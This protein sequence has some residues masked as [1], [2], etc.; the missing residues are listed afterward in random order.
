MNYVNLHCHTECSP[1]DGYSSINEYM[2]RVKDI[3]ATSLAITDHGTLHGH[4]EFQRAAKDSGIKP[5]LGLE[6]YFSPTDRF[7]RR[8]KKNR[9]E[10]DSIYHHLIL[11]PI[12][13]NGLN[14]LNSGNRIA[15]NEGFYL[16]PRWDM[17][18]LKEY[19]E[20]LIVLSGC[21]GGPIASAFNVGNDD[22]AYRWAKE[23]YDVFGDRFYI[24]L[25]KDNHI[26]NPDVNPKLFDLSDKLSIKPVIT[27]DCHAASPEDKI[28]QEIF[29]ILSSHPKLDRNADL[30]KAQ[31]M[32]LLE[33]FDYLYPDRKMTFKDFDLYLHGYEEK[34]NKMLDLGVDRTDIYENTVAIADRI[35]DYTYFSAQETLP[36]IV[37]NP[38]IT[39]R[40][41]T[42][43]GLI[44]K[45]LWD[46]P[47]YKERANYELE[48]IEGKGF[49][50]Y[51]LVM[52]DVVGWAHKQG[53]RSGAG[54]GSGAGSVVNYALC[55]TDVDPLV[56]NL[57]FE[58]FLDPERSDWPDVDWDIQDSR[59]D[60]VKQYLAEKYGHV[61]NITTVNTYKGKKALKDAARALGVKF[62]EVN[63]AMK[64][65]EGIDEITGHDVIAAFKK[66]NPDFNEK[67][68]DVVKI[69]EKL[70]GRITGYGLHA[71]GIIVA[72][73]PI[74]QYAPMETR[75]PSTSDERVEA[76][77][78][79]YRECEKLGL[80][81][82]DLLGLKTLTVVEDCIDLIKQN[83][84]VRVDIDSVS[85]N[86]KGV[87]K[88]LS[89]GKTLG[90]FQAEASPYTK[91]L[92]KMGC[93]D[94]NDLVVS[95]ALVRPGAWNAIGEDYIK[96]KRKGKI[97]KIHDDVSY[98]MDD[99]FG[100]PIYQEQMM[101]LSVDLAGFTV[102]ESNQ[103]RRGIG[104]KKREIIDAFKPMFI[105]GSTKK[106]DK[107]TAEKLWTS[108]EEAGA[109][110]FN[111]SHAVAYSL[112]SY[113]T[114]WL[115]Y[116]YPLEFMCALLR[117]EKKKDLITDYLL[118]CKAMGIKIKLP[119]INYSDARFKVEGDS[120]RMGLSGVKYL[121]DKLSDRII[122]GGPYE[123][124]EQFKQ[125]VLK[126]GSGLN[127]RVLS[128][129][130]TF[131]GATFDDNPR[132]T[133]YRSYLYEY[134]NIPAFETNGITHN[135]RNSITALED[136]MDDEAF[137]VLA[138]VKNV[139]RSETWA[140]VDMVDSS[141][142]AGAFVNPETDIQKGKMYIF[143]I[144][145][146]RI[147]KAIDI[148]NMPE[149][150]TMEYLRKPALP[151]VPEGQWMIVT[152][153]ARK[154]KANKNIATLIIAD[155]NK[156]L[157]SLTVF[158][159]VFN[160]VRAIARIGSIRTINIG[161]MRDGTEIV[162][163][164]Y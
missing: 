75:K 80:I 67:Y 1:L 55:I 100:Y 28:M 12:N 49:A 83:K 157:K 102:G 3:G 82:I 7:D 88:M 89:E 114:A 134:L 138:M 133:D 64:C 21:M 122:A 78:V 17:E 118:E 53:I 107:Q 91:L 143:L 158:D 20:D 98:F 79:D 57:L 54:R 61:A 85:L 42:K 62:S 127:T 16:K 144:G 92:I 22:L 58:R 136:Y 110:A 148:E 35:M 145:N 119:H 8:A 139:K 69:A 130:N 65:L 73:K 161:K 150:T 95:N 164:I 70:H 93:E 146:N 27:D 115:K 66:L 43:E 38:D 30:S 74:A 149:N 153:E 132:R 6:A 160:K 135:M 86:D 59:R 63:K 116:H 154:T 26:I 162:K 68:P 51:F 34:R 45:D 104:K 117:N 56:Y 13:D 11:L 121:S 46:K 147:I 50:N 24:E 10:A 23:F 33:R 112:L 159:S 87:F 99:T 128:A 94:F 2:L 31:K 47:G 140:R 125:F 108:F 15:W 141:G 106:I 151:E 29:L 25:Q 81:K 111:L 97:V 120:L 14:N 37:E 48:I 109:Y 156:E 5:I 101:K 32:D 84:G 71:A 18:L 9:E 72:N 152:A 90:V 76:V 96:A 103:L 77:A 60:E 41:M 129:L 105:E 39:L 155:A 137:F 52:E 126:K 40:K 124:Y 142:T 4:R 163:D 113:K 19:G 44:K 36:D 131:G 123:S